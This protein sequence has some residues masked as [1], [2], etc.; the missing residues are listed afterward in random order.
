MANAPPLIA[1]K[2][3]GV[4][5]WQ[6][7]QGGSADAVLLASTFWGAMT[8]WPAD[9]PLTA[10]CAANE[11]GAPHPAPGAGCSCGIYAWHPSNAVDA[12]AIEPGLLCGEGSLPTNVTGVI[13]AWGRVEVHA[14]GFRAE[15]ARP[16][17]LFAEADAPAERRRMIECLAKAYRATVVEVEDGAG[18]AARVDD[19]PHGIDPAG[20]EELVAP[21]V[22]LTLKPSASGHMS[23][24]KAIALGGS[25]FVLDG[26]DA[27]DRWRPELEVDLPGVRVARV[28]GAAFRPHAL[29]SRA[30]DPGRPLRLLPEPH[31]LH[32]SNAIGIWDE[33][34]NLQAGYVPAD[35]APAVGRMLRARTLKTA[36][37]LWQ[38][39]DLT[40]GERIGLHFLLSAT[41]HIEVIDGVAAAR[42]RMRIVREEEGSEDAEDNPNPIMELIADELDW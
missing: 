6:L 32:D 2:I 35:L 29:Q 18:L 15:H 14:D 21:R 11:S 39:R 25:G 34:L 26:Y 17:T 16:V 19:L 30:F 31:N 13:E 9:R 36:I 23:G 33:H 38:W 5:S 28:A 42:R 8:Y 10:R 41:E 37:S 24:R 4:R 27:P 22:E 12:M 3:Q 7:L 1:G 40:D 20:V